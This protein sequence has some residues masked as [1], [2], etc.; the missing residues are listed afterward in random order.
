MSIKREGGNEGASYEM[1]LKS[2]GSPLGDDLNC[3]W[4]LGALGTSRKNDERSI[5]ITFRKW[6]LLPNTWKVSA[7]LAAP[8]NCWDPVCPEWYLNLL[9]FAVTKYRD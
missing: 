2:V 8:Q 1:V 6:I 3:C 5:V 7:L 9:S 4:V